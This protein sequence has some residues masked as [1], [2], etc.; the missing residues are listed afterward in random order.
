VLSRMLPGAGYGANGG[1]R[2]ADGRGFIH[3]VEASLEGPGKSD[4]KELGTGFRPIRRARQAPR[5]LG[6]T[7]AA[8]SNC[9]LFSTRHGWN[10]LNHGRPRQGDCRVH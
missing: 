7:A 2:A 1:E 9:V 6:R 10:N 5:P 4:V 8:R 3:G